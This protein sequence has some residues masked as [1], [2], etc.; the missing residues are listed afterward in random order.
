MTKLIEGMRG[1]FSDTEL[2]AF[3]I[4]ASQPGARDYQHWQRL[5]QAAA[6][7]TGCQECTTHSYLS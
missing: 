1:M 2:H 6:L 5:A 7:A 3:I 4:T